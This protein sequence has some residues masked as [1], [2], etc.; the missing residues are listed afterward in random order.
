MNYKIRPWRIENFDELLSFRFFPYSC[1][2]CTFWESLNFDDKTKK[3]DAVQIKRNWLT[4]VSKDFGNCGFIAYRNDKP[5]GF[6]QYAPLKYL[7]TISKYQDFTPSSNTIF[8]TCLYIPNRELR[9]KGIGK[10][11]FE[12]IAW[13]LKNKGY[14][15]IETFTKIHD[16]PSN[17]ISDWLIRP[18]AFFIKMGFHIIQQKNNIAHLRKEF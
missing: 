16:T 5:V 6:T 17:N 15:S 4:Y 10:Q 1:K 13:D 7:P 11:L 2:Y 18:L 9:G 14:K 8:L 3:E 12:R